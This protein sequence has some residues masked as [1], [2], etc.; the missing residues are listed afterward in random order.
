V[1]VV[2]KDAAKFRQHAEECR[3]LAS[4]MPQHRDVLLQMAATWETCAKDAERRQEGGEIK[5][6]AAKDGAESSES[7]RIRAAR[8][9]P[10][11]TR[12]HRS[13]PVPAL[14]A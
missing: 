11:R 14:A 6:R 1:E 4:S 3:R 9:P 12:L 7:E 2:V 8:A 5:H 13:P 10:G